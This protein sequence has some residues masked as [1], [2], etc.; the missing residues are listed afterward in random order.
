MR[1]STIFSPL[2]QQD[3]WRRYAVGFACAVMAVVL[4]A[5]LEPLL[6][7]AGF[8]VTVY[9]AVV[10]SALIC[11]L[12]PSILCAV[13]ATGGVVYWFVNRGELFL[14]SN[15][16]SRRELHGLIACI[17]VCPVLIALGEANRRKQLQL[18][19]AQD[20]LEQ[21]VK[22]RTAELSQALTD[23]ESEVRTRESAEEQ[24]RRLSVR[25]MRVQDEERR[26]MARDLHDSAGQTLAALKMSID[27]LKQEIPETPEITR[28]LLDLDSLTDEALQEIRTTSYLLHPP[29]LD[30]SGFCSAARWFVEGFTKRSGIRVQCEIPE[31]IER[32]SDNVE[33]V[34]FRILQESLTNVHRHSGATEA[35]VT[36]L[37]R[38]KEVVLR[39]SDNGR[40]IPEER[41]K[42]FE[43]SKCNVGVG[44]AGMRERVRELGGK[45]A[46]HSGHSGTT[47]SVA[48][49]NPRTLPVERSNVSAA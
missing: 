21:R 2:S 31:A 35:M 33:M 11:G 15:P 19:E 44:I 7:H 5:I 45:L 37:R 4:R 27:L 9:I 24:L 46:V 49:S 26:R 12:G 22:K 3:L 34:L 41:L 38:E 8:Y 13:L 16:V 10:F 29:L 30:E 18:N 43:E 1:W 32:L 14:L 20:T 6:G 47:I 28:A 25:L 36:L 39:V 48:L 42:A 40:G 17:L 23:L